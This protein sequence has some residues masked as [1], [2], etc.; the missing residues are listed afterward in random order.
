MSR[1]AA[2]IQNLRLYY[3]EGQAFF[4][5][6]EASNLNS[7]Y[8][9]RR[10]IRG[11]I[12][13]CRCFYWPEKSIWYNC[14]Y[15]NFNILEL[16]GNQICGYPAIYRTGHSLLTWMRLT[17]ICKVVCGVPQGSIL[18]PRLFLLNIN[19]LCKVSN[20]VKFIS[21][22]DDT[23]IYSS[24]FDLK[25]L[26]VNISK[27]LEKLNEWSAL[28]KLSLNVSKTNVM[29]FG[30]RHSNVKI[31]LRIGDEEIE[32]VFV[33]KFLGVLMDNKFN[34]KEHICM[35]KLKLAKSTA[36]II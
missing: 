5:S 23:N 6:S 31:E 13:Y 9:W 4:R 22:A 10:T 25:E 18:G 3:T 32:K 34:W 8:T 20:I 7:Y 30:N 15:K 33:T 36:I 12:R 19:G 35:I 17:Q 29:R 16:E 26:C 14:L 2:D 27:E 28:N 21:F 24:G 1:D 11:D